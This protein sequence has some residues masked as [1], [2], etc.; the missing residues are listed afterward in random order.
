MK[1][2]IWSNINLNIEDWR[3]GFEETR[4][5]DGIEKEYDDEELYDWMERLNDDY[6]DDERINLNIEVD[7]KILIIADL[8]LWD[9][10]HSAYKIMESK[11][12]KD[13]L[14]SKCDLA[15]WYSDGK[16]IRFKGIHHDGTNHYLYR[17]I[18]ND[19][20]VDEFLD[21]LYDGER[22]SDEE[23]EKYTKSLHPYIA[24]VYGWKD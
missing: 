21:E 4:E 20:D 7:G 16:D 5:E 17:V 14:Y 11:N 10:R 8:G 24:K 19:V 6:L 3:S 13:I 12:I 2:T 1:H 22:I 9:G 23:I 15:E 18:R